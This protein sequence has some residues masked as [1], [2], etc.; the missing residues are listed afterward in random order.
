MSL[1]HNSHLNLQELL[2]ANYYA[3]LHQFLFQLAPDFQDIVDNFKREHFGR[4]TVGVHIRSHLE[5]DTFPMPIIREDMMIQV[6]YT[7]LLLMSL[8]PLG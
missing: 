8:R 6:H 7:A 2:P 5:I 3:F 1:L 4:F